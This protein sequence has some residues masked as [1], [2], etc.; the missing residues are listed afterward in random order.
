[1]SSKTSPFFNVSLIPLLCF[2]PLVL[3]LHITILDSRDENT[4]TW[5]K[6]KLHLSDICLHLYVPIYARWER[7][8]EREREML[9]LFLSFTN[10]HINQISHYFSV[11]YVSDCFTDWKISKNIYSYIC[12]YIKKNC[13][14]RFEYN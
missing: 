5:R 1:V 6:K 3:Y 12:I 9:I 11:I 13:M 2:I 14:A 4:S 8:R 7:E 10:F